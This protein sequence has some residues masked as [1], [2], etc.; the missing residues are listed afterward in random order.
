[1]KKH[2]SGSKMLSLLIVI[3]LN[4]IS[5]NN[6]IA[7]DY[8]IEELNQFEPSAMAAMAEAAVSPTDS[9][10]LVKLYQSTNGD[11]WTNKANWLIPGKRISTWYGITLV[12]DE[13][14][15]IR[16]R[17]NNLT[18][19]IPTELGDILSL[20]Y[21]DL[22]TNKITGSIPKEIGNLVNLEYLYLAGN[23][24]TGSIPS[25]LSQLSKL[26][27][28]YLSDN[29]LDG[30]I[31]VELGS[32]P[33]LKW[34]KLSYNQLSGEIPVELSQL[35]RIEFLNLSENLLIGNIPGSLGDLATLK[36]LNLS[37]NLLSGSIPAELGLLSATDLEQLYLND[38][39]LTG[40]IPADLGDLTGLK[41]LNLGQNQLTG[42]IPVELGQLTNLS[43]LYLDGNLLDGAIPSALNQIATM[44]WLNLAQNQLTGDIPSEFWQMTNLK[45]IY[46]N[47]NKLT[48]TIPA[49]LNLITNLKWLLLDSNNL[50][51]LPDLTVP[52]S[53]IELAVSDNQLT[54][55]HIESNMD[56]IPLVNFSYSP[57]DSIGE[58]LEYT[59][60]VG[61]SLS[62]ELVTGGTQN[63]YQW[64]KDGE[65]LVS[66]TTST[67]DLPVLTSTDGG[68]YYC[69]VTNTQVSGLTLTSRKINLM[70]NDN[71][72]LNFTAG[73]NIFSST[74]MPN[75]SNLQHILQP[76]IDAGVLKK[77][78]D[79]R[80][81]V[82][83]DYGASNGGWQNNIGNMRNTEGYKINVTADATLNVEGMAA[84]F[85]FDIELKAGWNII[86]WPTVNEQDGKDVFQL[87]IDEGKLKKVMDERGKVIEDY[88][89]SNGGWVNL[90]GNFKPGEGYKVN[91]N[92]AC[93]L[94]ITESGTKSAVTT[95]E[96]VNA[97]HFQPAYQG[98]GV[99]HMNINL[100]NITEAGIMEDD[101][102]GIFDGNICVG[103]YK[104][105]N[106]NSSFI[107][108]IA[109]ADDALNETN[110][111]F[112]QG[113]NIQLKLFRNEKEYLL[114]VLPVNNTS[115]QFEKNRTIFAELNSNLNTG[116]ESLD[117]I[118]S[119]D[120]YP[121]PFNSLLNI[122]VKMIQREELTVEVYD[123]LSR[124]VIQLFSGKAEGTIKLQWEGN[125]SEG[126]RVAPGV[127][128]CR[129]N[130]LIKKVVLN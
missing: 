89:A 41:W 65:I 9:M 26:L 63:S 23:K 68:M 74:V 35:P 124:R 62:Y 122:D 7:R 101:E 82:I 91:V 46:L 8:L 47:G 93:T 100:V 106:G 104:V 40:G 130:G 50:N 15:E 99:D 72:D 16:L 69:E 88:G 54:F 76:L 42:S 25:E 84:N 29:Q 119:L 83:E 31:P 128:I 105:A 92:T 87:L 109:S 127:Y 58:S 44:E 108:L 19:T 53:L 20:Q 34:L 98:H 73:W 3:L 32:L 120:F 37:G 64:Y 27:L 125:D 94:T 113:H 126:N 77:V 103:A 43:L 12:A 115:L 55:E 123:L 97:L 61:E 45:L 80:G 129:V 49:A 48:G 10:A 90:I 86:S 116:I 39:Q 30:A 17:K 60:N 112:M 118:I 21:L 78:I 71:I 121:N 66:Q 4:S 85:P 52:A 33:L 28:L 24:L 107:N 38:N 96:I 75:D 102:I 111:G 59:K 14:T 81:K 114:D 57:Q 2:L 110:D 5:V 70:V 117:D 18:G 56:L 51:S 67:L 1:M 6:L 11:S 36:W 95:P 22:D 79:E 13:V